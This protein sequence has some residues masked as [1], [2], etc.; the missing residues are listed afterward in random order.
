MK[1]I[2]DFIP[3]KVI[4]K[5][6]NINELSDLLIECSDKNI[7]PEIQVINYSDT[8]ITIECSNSSVASILKFN[9]EKYL[10]IFKDFGMY[11]IQDI[12]IKLK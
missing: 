7:Q 3:N 11:N 8:T 4:K 9:R 6:K 12:K 5:K 1:K 2:S 10:K